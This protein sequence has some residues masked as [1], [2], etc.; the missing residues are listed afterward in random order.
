MTPPVQLRPSWC[1]RNQS[2]EEYFIPDFE[3]KHPE[4]EKIKEAV[5]LRKP[6]GPQSRSLNIVYRPASEKS[7]SLDQ[8]LHSLAEHFGTEAS[9]AYH[10][11]IKIDDLYFELEVHPEQIWKYGPWDEHLKAQVVKEEEMGTTSMTDEEILTIGVSMDHRGH[12]QCD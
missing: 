7:T 12:A 11:A 2:H 5:T 4:I 3:A 9:W 10:W 6:T 1:A 8:L